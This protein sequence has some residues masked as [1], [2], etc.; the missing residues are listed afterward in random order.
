MKDSA[1]TWRRQDAPR[2]LNRW[3]PHV[4]V[5]RLHIVTVPPSGA[6]PNELW[7][8]FAQVLGVKADGYD[9]EGLNSNPSLDAVQTEVLRRFNAG[10][11]GRLPAPQP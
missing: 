5:E 10:L 9:L 6:K 4:P 11:D 2:I 8:R 7:N 1:K 3:R